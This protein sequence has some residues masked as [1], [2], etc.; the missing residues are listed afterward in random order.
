VNDAFYLQNFKGVKNLGYHFDD[1]NNEK[2]KKGLAGD[3]L[4]FDKYLTFGLKLT[5]NYCPLLSSWG[6]DPFVFVN[7][8]LAPN[9]DATQAPDQ[10]T[11]SM[12]IRRT[13][14]DHLRL[15][16]GFGLTMDLDLVAI[17]C[18]YN[19][20]VSRQKNELRNDFQINFGID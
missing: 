7:T 11:T 12:K 1:S 16:A 17:E 3:I 14:I 9:R 15:T 2:N 18:Y 13:L 8:A 5:H 6:I 20:Y 4:G 10:E 19:A